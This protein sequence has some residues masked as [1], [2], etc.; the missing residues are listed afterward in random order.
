MLILQI[1]NTGLMSCLGQGG[2]HSLSALVSCV[3]FYI[4]KESIDFALEQ[5]T[6]LRSNISEFVTD[7]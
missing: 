6:L 3:I 7:C 1:R 4:L 2:L 5:T